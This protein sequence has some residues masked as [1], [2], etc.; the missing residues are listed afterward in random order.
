MLLFRVDLGIDLPR[1]PD[2]RVDL[3]I[4]VSTESGE[5]HGGTGRRLARPHCKKTV[6]ALVHGRGRGQAPGTLVVPPQYVVVEFFVRE[7][8]QIPSLGWVTEVVRAIAHVAQPP[9][10]TRRKQ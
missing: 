8:Q 5:G 3:G 7:L 1:L 4:D 2:R 6:D 10:H 9:G